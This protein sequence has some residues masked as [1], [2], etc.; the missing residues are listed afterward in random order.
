MSRL[1]TEA[2]QALHGKTTTGLVSI[3]AQ[4]VK[5]AAH[6]DRVCEQTGNLS[7]G[8]IRIHSLKLSRVHESVPVRHVDGRLVKLQVRHV[9]FMEDTTRSKVMIIFVDLSERMHREK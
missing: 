9:A 4:F 5:H 8:A 6:S 1:T 7:H 3:G 2:L